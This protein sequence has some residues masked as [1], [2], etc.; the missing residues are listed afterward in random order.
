MRSISSRRLAPA[1]AAS[2]LPVCLII[3][4]VDHREPDRAESW[5]PDAAAALLAQL[6]G[7]T[8][9]TCLHIDIGPPQRGQLAPAQTAENAEQHQG[10]VP[11]ID[12]IGQDVD[13]GNCQDRPLR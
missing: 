12:R 4:K 10:S 5:P 9:S 2:W 3:V 11:A 6:S 8:D 7:N 1:S 13:L